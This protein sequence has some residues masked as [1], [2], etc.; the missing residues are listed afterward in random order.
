MRYSLVAV[1]STGPLF[2]IRG[3]EEVDVQLVDGFVE[4]VHDA[5][6][7]VRFIVADFEFVVGS[8]AKRAD[9]GIVVA[10]LTLAA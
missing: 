6:I 7:L 2:V 5:G 10:G 9:V 1:D 4:L 8:G 3:I